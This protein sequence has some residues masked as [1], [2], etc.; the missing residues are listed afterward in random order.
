[1]ENDVDVIEVPDRHAVINPIFAFAELRSVILAFW[2]HQRIGA[3][4][5]FPL[6]KGRSLRVCLSASDCHRYDDKDTK[7]EFHKRVP[8]AQRSATAGESKHFSSHRFSHSS[9]V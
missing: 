9:G 5:R 7:D 6:N 1:M 3:I 2:E 4:R 8:G